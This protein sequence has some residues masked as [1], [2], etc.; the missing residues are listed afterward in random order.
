MLI[1]FHV[2]EG[3]E[4]GLWWHSAWQQHWHWLYTC[5]ESP[6][7]APAS[8]SVYS[9]DSSWM[10]FLLFIINVPIPQT[11]KQKEDNFLHHILA[12][13]KFRII[14]K[15]IRECFKSILL[16]LLFQLNQDN[17]DE[18]RES[19]HPPLSVILS[20]RP[21]L[22]QQQE[23]LIIPVWSQKQRVGWVVTSS[24]DQW[25]LGQEQHARQ[26]WI[27]SWTWTR[28]ISQW[29]TMMLL[30]TKL[31]SS[32]KIFISVMSEKGLKTRVAWTLVIDQDTCPMS[33]SRPDA[34]TPLLPSPAQCPPLAPPAPDSVCQ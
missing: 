30:Q 11:D 29:I 6:Q 24:W 8:R 32:C 5:T 22:E 9:A 3:C 16:F 20:R 26:G 25:S 10:Q 23:G 4:E 14:S 34:I 2:G 7:P 13:K 17:P 19:W 15:V 18:M 1:G 28:L 31:I 27:F 12:K 21:S 33:S